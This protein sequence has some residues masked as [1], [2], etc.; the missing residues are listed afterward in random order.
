MPEK[1][2]AF[3]ALTARW[4][5]MQDRF[6]ENWI[7]RAS[8]SDAWRRRRL[9]PVSTKRRRRVVGPVEYQRVALQSRDDRS[10]RV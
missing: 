2:L 10:F 3:C 1:V 4:R 6:F 5:G 7:E 8:T 9:E